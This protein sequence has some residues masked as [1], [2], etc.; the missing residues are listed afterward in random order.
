MAEC[1]WCHKPLPEGRRKYCSQK[2]GQK[3]WY[4]ENHDIIL[5]H[6]DK[7]NDLRKT[8]RIRTTRM[9]KRHYKPMDLQNCQPEKMGD[10][11]S[12]IYAYF[13]FCNAGER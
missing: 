6:R 13:D 9:A 3:A 1:G 10:M 12:K 7:V 8:N 2:C 5:K 11:V 4:K